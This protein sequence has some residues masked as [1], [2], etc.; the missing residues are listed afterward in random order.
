MLDLL[1]I[2]GASKGIGNS[3][4]NKCSSIYK[5]IIAI[6]SSNK[7]NELGIENA[8]PLC[9]DLKETSEVL[10]KVSNIMESFKNIKNI[11]IVLCAAQLG[12]SG[13]ILS[14][15]SNLNEWNDLYKC[16]VLGNLA[17]IR[18]CICLMKPGIKIRIAM[19]AGG[20]AAY[21][22]PDFFGYSLSKVAIVRAVENLAIEFD[23][24]KLDA[25]VIAIAPGAVN[26]DILDKVIANGGEIRTKTDISEPTNFVYNFLTDKFPSKKLNGKFLHVRD[27]INDIDFDV[28]NPDIFKLRRIQ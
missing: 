26:T 25:S 22:Y 7:I 24:K 23:L 4:I 20:G 19:F 11:S 27:I 18:G 17:V 2:T 13:G 10:M 6:S 28:V 21:G 8:I 15:T 1:I 5:N 16:N 9:L 12:N 14:E 3:I